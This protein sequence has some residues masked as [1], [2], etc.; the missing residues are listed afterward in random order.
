MIL[1]PLIL[2]TGSREC[3]AEPV[4]KV[5]YDTLDELEGYGRP[6][7]VHGHH[8]DGA[9]HHADLWG[10][11]V[12]GARR[13]AWVERFPANWT[14]FGRGAGPARNTAMTERIWVHQ[15]AGA[16]VVVL[17]FPRGVSLGTRNMIERCQGA[18]INDVRIYEQEM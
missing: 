9:D 4:T 5:L 15:A 7:L 16:L 13:I 12:L 17:A 2:V 8:K 18:G 1:H 11:R 14:I 3:E 10:Y 6:I